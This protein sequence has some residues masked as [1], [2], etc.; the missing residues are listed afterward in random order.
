MFC[1]SNISIYFTNSPLVVVFHPLVWQ[2]TSSRAVTAAAVMVAVISSRAATAVISSPSSR[3][4]TERLS[5]DMVWLLPMA[6]NLRHTEVTVSSSRRLLH[7]RRLPPLLVHGRRH[8][9]LTARCITTIR[10]RAKLSGTNL[11][12]CR[13][14]EKIYIDDMV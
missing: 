9:L 3:A 8:K 5:R 14:D 1:V 12:E 2:N 13:K 6:S 4:T 7:H 11:L 10:P